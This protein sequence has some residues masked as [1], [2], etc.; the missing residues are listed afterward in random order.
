MQRDSS[1]IPGWRARVAHATRHGQKVKKK[2]KKKAH[3][4]KDLYLRKIS[5]CQKEIKD[6]STKQN[7]LQ[8]SS[9]GREWCPSPPW[10]APFKDTSP[11]DRPARS[12]IQGYDPLLSSLCSIP[13]SLAWFSCCLHGFSTSPCLSNP[14]CIHQPEGSFRNTNLS[15]FQE[16]HVNSFPS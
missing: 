3:G 11:F 16:S 2:K 15:L 10:P 14:P 6:S 4:A 1:S 5:H 9:R 8:V 7:L 12:L 13:Q